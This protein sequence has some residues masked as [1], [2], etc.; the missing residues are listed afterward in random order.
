MFLVHH[1]PCHLEYVSVLTFGYSVLL[2]CVS[3]SE[4]PSDSFLSKVY[5]EGVGEGL[6]VV[7]RSKVSY[8][9]IGCLF[10]FILELLEV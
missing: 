8:M 10:D 7:V 1:C 3:A 9:T 4:L 5:C 6:F 2:R